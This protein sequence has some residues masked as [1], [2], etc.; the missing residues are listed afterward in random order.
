MFLVTWVLEGASPAH[1]A[2]QSV[3]SA[4]SSHADTNTICA[5]TQPYPPN[6][7]ATLTPK[8]LCAV[9]CPCG[10]LP[11]HPAPRHQLKPWAPMPD[12]DSVRV[13]PR[14]PRP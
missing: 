10:P 5:H 2:C 11:P 12:S 1:S 4:L 3:R 6:N 9:A 7:H 8:S 13:P 14:P